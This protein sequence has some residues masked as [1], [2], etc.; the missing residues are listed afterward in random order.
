MRR[1]IREPASLALRRHVAQAVQVGFAMLKLRLRFCIPV[2]GLLSSVSGGCHAQ[3]SPTT[4]A[5]TSVVLLDVNTGQVLQ[6]SGDV[7]REAVP[8]SVLKPFVL[9]TAIRSGAVREHETI[10]CTGALVVAG[11]NLACS[12]PRDVTVLDARQALAKSCN[13]YFAAVASRMPSA[14]LSAGLRSY[15]LHSDGEPR[16]A[17]ERILLA[18]GLREIRVSTMQ[19]AQAYRHLAGEM[20]ASSSGVAKVVRDGMLQSVE[21]GM[22]N[23]ARS[24]GVTLGGKTGTVDDPGGRSHG[25]FAGILFDGLDA[26]LAGKVIVVFVPNGN[27]ADAAAFAGTFVRRGARR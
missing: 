21:T 23:A 3:A 8:G 7:E 24:Q 15:G 20:N 18:L 6:R 9:M 14:T 26:Q 1:H 17:D 11:H 10:P 16:D 27:G 25:W 22:A 13:S 2:V 4:R 19:L 5:G 12:H